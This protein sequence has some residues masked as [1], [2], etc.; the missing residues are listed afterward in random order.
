M[1]IDDWVRGQDLEVL[2]TF[3]AKPAIGPNDI[4]LPL[5]AVYGTCVFYLNT[6]NYDD[7]PKL[8]L[9][10]VYAESMGPDGVMKNCFGQKRSPPLGGKMQLGPGGLVKGAITGVEPPAAAAADA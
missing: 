6:L 7:E 10:E 1:A 3:S 4:H 8:S 9:A 5:K 2:R